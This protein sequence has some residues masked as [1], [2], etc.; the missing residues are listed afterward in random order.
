VSAIAWLGGGVTGITIILSGIGF[1]VVRGHHDLLG[2]SGF[3]PIQADTLIIEGIRCVYNSFLYLLGGLF[4]FNRFTFGIKSLILLSG[5]LLIV[6]RS[7]KWLVKV[8]AFFKSSFRRWIVLGLSFGGLLIII[9]MFIDY[10]M[11]TNLLITK[12][13]FDNVILKRKTADGLQHLRFQYTFLVSLLVFMFLWL[14][15]LSLFFN[16][17]SDMSSSEETKSSFRNH[18]WQPVYL[19]FMIFILIS[20]FFLPM[21]YGKMVKSNEYC[22]VSLVKKLGGIDLFGGWLLYKDSNEIILYQSD[23][24]VTEPIKIFKRSEFSQ[25]NLISYGNIF[26]EL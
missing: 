26:S 5:L 14:R 4:S 21:N 25:I 17:E 7:E 12:P 11:P 1:L 3:V 15:M 22:K 24:S 13:A 2:I 20:L 8:Q 23:S 10:E 9:R 19:I 18:W 16:I 6:I